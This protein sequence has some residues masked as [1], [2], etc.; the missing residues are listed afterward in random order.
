MSACEKLC[1]G[2]KKCFTF[3]FFVLSILSF[4]QRTTLR[5]L[6]NLY[7]LRLFASGSFSLYYERNR[8]LK[9]NETVC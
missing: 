9:M 1:E 2:V 4:I 8:L 6:Q 7:G 5:T 3:Y